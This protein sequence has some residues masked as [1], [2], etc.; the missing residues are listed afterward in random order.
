ML[1]GVARR[2]WAARSSQW[3]SGRLRIIS[4]TRSPAATPSCAQPCG[5]RGGVARRTSPHVHV[6]P[7]ARRVARIECSSGERRG[8]SPTS[9]QEALAARSAR[10][11]LA[12]TSSMVEPVV[13]SSQSRHVTRRSAAIGSPSDLARDRPAAPMTCRA[14]RDRRGSSPHAHRRDRRRRPHAAR[15]AQRQAQGL[16]PGRPRRRDA[17]GARRA[18]RARSRRSSTTSSWAASCRSAS[19]PSTSPATPCSP[20][21]CP[22]RCPAR[23]STASAARASRPPTSPRRA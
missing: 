17:E 15:Q 6:V 1:T 4:S 18:Q 13:A 5:G 10:R 16:A 3:K 20:P 11:R 21:A 22:R 8:A 9:S 19:R 23:R 12:S 2:N 14:G 7:A